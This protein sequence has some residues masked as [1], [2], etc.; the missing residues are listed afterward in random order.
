MTP[1]CMRTNNRL[2]AGCVTVSSSLSAI[3]MFAVRFFAY[4][5]FYFYYYFKKNNLIA[6]RVPV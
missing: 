1:V 6:Q 4:C 5:F 2:C 3:T